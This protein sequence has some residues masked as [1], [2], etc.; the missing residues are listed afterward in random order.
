MPFT[1]TERFDSRR[2]V[3]SK[4]REHGI[5]EFTGFG[6]DDDAVARA[7]FNATIPTVFTFMANPLTR[8]DFETW[9]LGG[10]FWRAVANFG[11]DTAPV[12]PAVGIPGPPTPVV[13]APNP[14]APL[15]ADFAFDFTGV[16]ERIT[17]S[18]ETKGR[19]L[20]DGSGLG[21][22]GPDHKGAIG[23]T[24]DG[25]VEGCEKPSPNL[26][27]SRTVTFASV[28]MAYIDTVAALVGTTNNAMFY[29]R[30]AG[31]QVFMGGNC[32]IDD[33]YRA[34]VTLKFTSR[35]NLTNIVICSGLTVATK[36]GSDYLWVSYKAGNNTNSSVQQPRA[37]YVERISDPADWSAF[38]IGV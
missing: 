28:T 1:I 36:L 21:N 25:Q 14:N 17:Q 27:W 30:P 34:K 9:T 5:M 3:Y 16:P 32:Q 33:T 7:A 23:V 6:T 8:L 22:D 24:A 2:H 12:Y 35:P 31:S 4:D 38:G 19:Y 15:G 13:A 10:L 29:G 11:P 20:R 26:E 18:K 37:A